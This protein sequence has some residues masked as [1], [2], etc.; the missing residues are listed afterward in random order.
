MNVNGESKVIWI[1]S[2]DV[3]NGKVLNVQIKVIDKNLSIGSD[4]NADGTADVCL[5]PSKEEYEKCGYDKQRVLEMIKK[6]SWYEMNVLRYVYGATTLR[7]P[8]SMAENTA[9]Y[10][11][12]RKRG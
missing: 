11:G 3:W 2:V 1:V 10:T 7:Y 12:N 9:S 8:S 6:S 5:Y 4:G